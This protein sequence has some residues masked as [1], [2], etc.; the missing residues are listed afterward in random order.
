MIDRDAGLSGSKIIEDR[1][2]MSELM[3]LIESQ[4]IG[5]VAAQE[6]DRFFRDVTQIQTNI[7]I[8][9]CRRNNVLVLTPNMIYDFNHPM[10]GRFHM[11][12][13]RERA[14]QAAD[15]VEY[16]IK[17]RLV[18]ARF[19]QSERGMW[20]GRVVAPGYMVDNRTHLPDGERNPNYRKYVRF[21]VFADI[22]L[23]Y[24]RLFQEYNG[25]MS[26]VS[27]HVDEHGPFYPESWEAL[28]P[29]GF[30]YR[31][32]FSRRSPITG[33]LCPGTQGLYYL[34]TNVVYIGHWIFRGAVEQWDNHEAIIPHD[35]FM[36][37]FNRLSKTDFH[38]EPNPDY[39]PYKVY[40]RQAKEDRGEEPPTYSG[41]IFSDDV[42][43][44]PHRRV[45][46]NWRINMQCYDY[47]SFA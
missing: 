4:S 45:A 23:T 18:K 28:L 38:G 6:V 13:F 14:Q 30:V 31:A 5:A 47:S 36:Y 20:D 42:P 3:R 12:M 7:F 33:Q 41:L 26:K 43:G 8:D 39:A 46:M 27:A 19:W 40:R 37:A 24:F 10:Q 32:N 17:G 16:Q 22:A 2:G 34:L 44:Y 25:A 29:E 21:P 35:L 15:Y 11:Q 9:A 1:P